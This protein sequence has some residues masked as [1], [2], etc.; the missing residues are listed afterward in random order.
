M[1]R[2]KKIDKVNGIQS[3]LQFYFLE[4]YF[5]HLPEYLDFGWQKIYVKSILLPVATHCFMFDIK[6]KSNQ[7]WW[8]GFCTLV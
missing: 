1:S 2:K 8:N 7:T 6:Y 5:R 3:C 4:K